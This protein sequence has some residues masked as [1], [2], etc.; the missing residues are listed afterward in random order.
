MNKVHSLVHPCGLLLL[1]LPAIV[2]E[3]QTLWLTTSDFGSFADFPDR[4]LASFTHSWLLSLGFR[5]I[6]K[7]LG[8]SLLY[9]TKFD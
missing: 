7:N 5:L 9:S 3:C 2:K 8:L 1:S 4:T 6:I